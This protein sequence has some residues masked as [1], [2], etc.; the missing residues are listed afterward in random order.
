MKRQT[1]K[2]RICS[3]SLILLF[4]F[5]INACSLPPFE[6]EVLIA[7]LTA[8]ESTIIT[9]PTCEP[10]A[11]CETPVVTNTE[12]VVKPLETATLTPEPTI[13]PEPTE[14]NTPTEINIP[15]IT[16]TPEPITYSYTI[17]P[18]SP[19]Y[20]ENVFHPDLG[21]NW[22]GIGG[23]VFNEMNLPQPYLI[24][25]VQGTLNGQ[26]V[27]FTTMTGVARF[28]GPEGYEIELSTIGVDSTG[29]L[30]I[31][32]FDLLGNQISESFF[33]DTFSAPD[34]A[35]IVFNFKANIP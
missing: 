31:S 8:D 16:I 29:E 34:K 32:L 5:L 20:M 35:Q 27:N 30:S 7:T 11:I 6:W 22:M 14:T 26:E 1:N 10:C 12:E 33:F 13:Q 18:G 19:V 24:V 4:G 3:V 2:R 17:Q 25:R 21:E 23:Q 28:L 9:C 15:T